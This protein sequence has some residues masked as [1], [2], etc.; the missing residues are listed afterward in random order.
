MDYSL[1]PNLYLL[2]TPAGAFSAL[3][4]VSEN[5][6]VYFL[7]E[8]LRNGG[9]EQISIDRLTQWSGLDTPEQSLEFLFQAQKLGWVQAFDEPFNLSSGSFEQTLSELLPHLSAERKVLLAD[10]Q[11]FCLH[12]CGFAP[13]VT[14]ELSALSGSLA[15]LHQRH[16][17]FLNGTLELHSNAWALMNA[18]GHSQLGFWPLHVDTNQ[19][20][21]VMA[22]QPTFNKPHLVELAIY[23]H[24]RF[25]G[26]KSP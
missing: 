21:L 10:L 13:E 18:A 2:P 19:F 20:M 17:R 16:Q 23:L 14:D 4:R 25:A 1:N 5:N 15:T 24:R 12:S 7:T 6:F 26:Q 3:T 11:G 9:S 8:L 22:G